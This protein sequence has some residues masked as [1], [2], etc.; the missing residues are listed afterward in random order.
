MNDLPNGPGEY[1]SA[2]AEKVQ[3]NIK[4]GCLHGENGF[5]KNYA[6]EKYFGKSF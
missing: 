3:G 5:F 6:G 1:E 4:D 2:F